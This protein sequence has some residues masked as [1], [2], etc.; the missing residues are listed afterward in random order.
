MSAAGDGWTE[1]NLYFLLSLRKKKMQTNLAGSYFCKQIW[2]RCR[3]LPAAGSA[4]HKQV[5]RSIADE[6]IRAKE[7]IG[8]RKRIAVHLRKQL[9]ERHTGR[10]LPFTENPWAGG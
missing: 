3:A 9:L 2:L 10:S 7:D 6:G 4:R 1:P 5:P 8:H